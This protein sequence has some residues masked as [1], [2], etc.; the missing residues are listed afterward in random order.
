[1]PEVDCCEE[2]I[3]INGVLNLVLC[4]DTGHIDS[5]GLEAV[6]KHWEYRHCNPTASVSVKIRKCGVLLV[7]IVGYF[8][9]YTYD[10]PVFSASM[11]ILCN[12]CVY[13]EHSSLTFTTR[14][15]IG[16]ELFSQS[17]ALLLCTTPST[18][19]DSLKTL[20]ETHERDEFVSESN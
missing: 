20:A 14:V 7:Y 11:Y 12:V 10:K 8:T 17:L 2:S 15:C 4:R 18:Y 16:G 9:L 6:I 13:G 1:M 3:L 5:I 19:K